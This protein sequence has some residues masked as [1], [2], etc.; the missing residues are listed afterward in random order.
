MAKLKV[1]FINATIDERWGE[2]L[3]RDT[4]ERLANSTA[5]QKRGLQFDSYDMFYGAKQ[6]PGNMGRFARENGYDAIVLSGSDKNTTDR[7]DPWVQ[8]YIRGLRDLLE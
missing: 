1:L 4:H 6:R 2:V 8:E 5:A 3:R 7:E